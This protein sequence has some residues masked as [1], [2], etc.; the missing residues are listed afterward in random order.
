L[1]ATEKKKKRKKEKKGIE[2]E[3]QKWKMIILCRR[4]AT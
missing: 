1:A 2:M 4:V 3:D